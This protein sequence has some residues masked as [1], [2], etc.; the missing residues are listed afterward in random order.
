MI[1][2][3]MFKGIDVNVKTE[4]D[5][6]DLPSESGEGKLSLSSTFP[7]LW[8]LNLVRVFIGWL[9]LADHGIRI[10]FRSQTLKSWYY[11][12]WTRIVIS[13]QWN[14]TIMF[15]VTLRWMK[16]L[17]VLLLNFPCTSA[18]RYIYVMNVYCMKMWGCFRLLCFV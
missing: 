7:N 8:L 10:Y 3:C 6:Y 13:N 2:F 15:P 17:I 9:E 11:W 16:F 18:G 12:V 4:R 5:R 14:C 1:S